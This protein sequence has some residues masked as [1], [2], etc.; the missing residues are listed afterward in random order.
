MSTIHLHQTTTLTPE[1]YVAGLTDFG[2]GRSKLF[3]NSADEYL[4]VHHRG[5]QRPT[6]RK[7]RAASGN[8]CTTTGP[9]P[10][11]SS[12]RRPTPTR[13][14]ARRATPTP[15]RVGPTARPTLTWSS[16]ATARTSRGGCSASC[17]GPSASAFW[18]RRLKTPSRPSK[19]GGESGS[20]GRAA[21]RWVELFA[22]GDT[23][24][25]REKEFT[26]D[27]R[28]APICI[29]LRRCQRWRAR[30]CRAS[31]SPGRVAIV[32][33]GYSGIGLETTRALACR[34]SRRSSFLRAAAPR[35]K[36]RLDGWANVSIDALDLMDPVSIDAFA[37]R[38]LAKAPT[39]CTCS[40][41]TQDSSAGRWNET[42]AAMK[43][44]SRRTISAISSSPLVSGPRSPR[45][46]RD[47][48]AVSSRGHAA[49]P[50]NFED[51][52]FERRPYDPAI[53]YGQSKSAN[54]LFA[55]WLDRLGQSD[56]VRAYSLHPGGMIES[57]FTRN[58]SAA[59][60]AASGYLDCSKASPSS[61]PRTTRKTLE[62][63]RGHQR[64]VRDKSAAYGAGRR[65]L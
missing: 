16:Y 65:L 40:S 63:R 21:K 6:S 54:A 2:P 1:Q 29:P 27:T 5:P 12:S 52:N 22:R 44:N 64:L 15:S 11:A 41:T 3:G 48:V 18:K 8:A 59:D 25:C 37:V 32:T 53:A 60:K 26:M 14:E 46:G 28:Q 31:I 36:R 56:G 13:G 49:A 4:K 23:S 62:Q 61:I 47:V 19:P 42:C 33:G 58:M 39:R 35:L 7:A 51:I 34:W 43:F 38:F 24:V 50:V 30:S 57:G 20:P 55:V 17:S 10:T 9:I 45:R